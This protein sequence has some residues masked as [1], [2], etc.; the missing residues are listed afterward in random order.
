MWNVAY[1]KN[2]LYWDGRAATLED[3]AKMAWS[4]G[5]LG[6]PADKLDDKAKQLAAIASG[7][8]ELFDAPTAFPGAPVTGELVQQALA[9]YERTLVC[10]ATAYDKFAA[11]DRT[12][13][14]DVQQRGLDLFLGKAQC[15]VCHT[16]PAFSMAKP[17]STAARTSTSVSAPT[18]R[19]TRS[20]SAA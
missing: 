1:F 17:A 6:V 15:V 7:L 12:A 8:Q 19:P 11:G 2:A 20:T 9:E 13:L 5:N 10:N 16:P 4:G 3:N 14:T 18:W